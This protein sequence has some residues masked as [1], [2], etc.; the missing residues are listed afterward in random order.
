[1]QGGVVEGRDDLSGAELLVPQHPETRTAEPPEDLLPRAAV[2][3]CHQPAR[4]QHPA[5]ISQVGAPH[6]RGPCFVA[7]GNE[8]TPLKRGV[9]AF[10]I[11]P[12]RWAPLSCRHCAW[13]RPG[14][15]LMPCARHRP[16]PPG[17][18]VRGHAAT[19]LRP[20]RPTSPMLRRRLP[21]TSVIAQPAGGF[22][23][24]RMDDSDRPG[25]IPIPSRSIWGPRIG[26]SGGV[27]PRIVQFFPSAQAGDPGK[28]DYSSILAPL[29]PP[30]S[31]QRAGYPLPAG[32]SC[33]P[34]SAG[35]SL[36]LRGRPARL[37]LPR[38]V[39]S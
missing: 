35:T 36:T 13:T 21:A 14:F 24:A 3:P 32:R 25:G 37:A 29:S 10:S 5:G 39:G 26:H 2:D 23:R 20:V 34:G 16:P 27:E 15:G 6:P 18:A 17:L 12:G 28:V 38:T 19:R 11:N 30:A 31:L 1:M 8:D 33:G 9:L 7:P 22:L 4:P